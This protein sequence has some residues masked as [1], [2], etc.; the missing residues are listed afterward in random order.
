MSRVDSF[1]LHIAY[2]LGAIG[3]LL[4]L[5]CPLPAREAE[6]ITS[7]DSLSSPTESSGVGLVLSGGG[8][9]GIYHIGVIKALEDSGV[10]IDYV[11][12]TSMGAIVAGLY[13]AG[14]SP[15]QMVELA[16]SGQIQQWLS[17]SIDSNYGAFY[18]QYRDIPSFISFRLG[19][20][21][22]DKGEGIQVGDDDYIPSDY[23]Y[24]SSRKDT[25]PR[26]SKASFFLP[27]SLIP[28]AQI[29]LAL[30]EIYT[31]ASVA[32]GEKFD[33][34]MVP[35]LCVASDMV[36]KQAVVLTE[37]DLGEA[38]R[39]SMALPLAFKPI[40]KDGMLLYDGGI[41]DN[42]PWRHL[43]QRYSP[44]VMIGVICTE[45]ENS[46]INENNDII[47]QILTLTTDKT[48]YR[49]PDGNI[50][51]ERN[52]DVSML[53][54]SSSAKSIQ[55][56]YEDTMAQ[57][58]SIKLR[59]NRHASPEL[60]KQ[61]RKEFTSKQRKMLFDGYNLTGLTQNQQ[62]YMQNSIHVTE[63]M[64]GGRER[65]EVM[66]YK[67][68]RENL[69]SLLAYGDFTTTYPKIK[70]DTLSEHY[71]F[72]MELKTKPQLELS[73]GGNL[74]STA[75]NQLYLG[76]DY[77]R[78]G[79]VAQQMYMD[80]YL[81]PVY[82]FGVVG[83]R[84]DFYLDRPIFTDY[85]YTYMT[86]DLDHGSFGNLTEVTNVEEISER[87]THFSVCFGFPTSKRSLLTLR[88][89]VGQSQYLYDPT[90]FETSLQD[91]DSGVL[92]VDKTS[93]G[94]LSSK[95]EYKYST[96]NRLLYPQSGANLSISAIGVWSRERNYQTSISSSSSTLPTDYHSWYGGQVKYEKYITPRKKKWFSL[97]FSLDA[98]YTNIEQ[99]GNPTASVLI[100]P[101]YQPVLHNQMVFIPD[102][103]ASKYLAVGVM[104]TF[105]II[106]NL[107]L[108]IGGYTMCREAL[109]VDGLDAEIKTRTSFQYIAEAALVYHTPL[110]P[111]SLAATKYDMRD[112]NNLYLTFNFG[113]AIFAPKGTF[114]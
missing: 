45:G 21:A 67:E 35:F 12:G 5:S 63:G 106:D 62:Q 17:F 79:S 2:T 65:K 69:Y 26:R 23:K 77:K 78:L 71:N 75:F 54:F 85:Y 41:Y 36:S 52:V 40:S 61:R 13:A 11:A 29:D 28:T 101:S 82:S 87:D 92:F 110:G 93:L 50:T 37:G 27:Q 70:F 94:Y 104:P 20:E 114:Y 57:M 103:S 10:P 66:D 107:L 74:S 19:I 18:R 109:D 43:Q 32:A 108:R 105:N 68:L 44:S 48:D 91:S 83:G 3:L 56:G 53:D 25:P 102:F 39:A 112:W 46:T 113:Y 30:S 4:T 60:V 22:W 97:G 24:S 15:D 86:K 76:L 88:G 8:A 96:L 90:D 58:D 38:V 89:N 99:I 84:T 98:V 72:E 33:S 31:P 51:I 16:V 42:Y 49:L 7:I 59:V 95:L 81:G 111:I 47:N 34:L 6:M 55:Q 80:L 14:Y 1:I 100:M 64:F 9:K 73:V